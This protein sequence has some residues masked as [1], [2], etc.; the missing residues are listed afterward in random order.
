MAFQNNSFPASR[1]RHRPLLP[2]ETP[3]SWNCARATD[4]TCPPPTPPSTTTSAI[5][6]TARYITRTLFSSLD[7]S[8][9]DD[10]ENF[11]ENPRKPLR[12][13]LRS[14]RILQ[15]LPVEILNQILNEV[16][17][18]S[19]AS[20]SICKCMHPE[21]D[22]KQLKR[23]YLRWK[24]VDTRNVRETC[25]RWHA[26]ASQ[27]HFSQRTPVVLDFSNV[28]HLRRRL[29]I[30]LER[31]REEQKMKQEV[32]DERERTE[33]EYDGDHESDSE[34]EMEVNDP[35]D[36]E[37]PRQYK[38]RRK[39][40]K[41]EKTITSMLSYFFLPEAIKS[42]ESMSVHSPLDDWSIIHEAFLAAFPFFKNGGVTLYLGSPL[43]ILNLTNVYEILSTCDAWNRSLQNGGGIK[44]WDL[45]FAWRE[46]TDMFERVTDG[47]FKGERL[48][49][50]YDNP[51]REFWGIDEANWIIDPSR[52]PDVSRNNSVAQRT[53]QKYALSR[54]AHEYILE[55]RLSCMKSDAKL[56]LDIISVARGSSVELP[57][58]IFALL[59]ASEWLP[60][61]RTS[62]KTCQKVDFREFIYCNE[63]KLSNPLMILLTV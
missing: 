31:R 57:I 42:S 27:E 25:S 61:L 50:Y 60:V 4:C 14:H 36:F 35:L 2:G 15:S 37:G 29:E 44:F 6:R 45:T 58:N 38:P 62:L 3:D 54:K 52:R 9:V 30:A 41:S 16:V 39:R 17:E 53:Q 34:R 40:R 26:W 63:S 23:K 1:S 55:Q 49:K 24:V 46:D 28:L 8:N 43:R 5:A 32:D 20:D 13:T 33:S 10:F 18:S 59:P 21:T 51:D 22:I 48:L 7:F 11:D 47:P 19:T 12:P 56:L